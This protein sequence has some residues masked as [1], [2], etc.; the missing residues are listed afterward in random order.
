MR[1]FTRNPLKQCILSCRFFYVQNLAAHFGNQ[2]PVFRKCIHPEAPLFASRCIEGSDTG[3]DLVKTNNRM[4]VLHQ[5]SKRHLTGSRGY[6]YQ[7][8]MRQ[9]AGI[10]CDLCREFPAFFYRYSLFKER[11]TYTIATRVD[12]PFIEPAFIEPEGK[13]PGNRIL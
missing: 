8:L 11:S 13:I 12:C 4:P 3:G 2:I 6:I 5:Y 7:N 10:R 9:E 1:T